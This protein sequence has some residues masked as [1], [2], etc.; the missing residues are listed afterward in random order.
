M[1]IQ[2][3]GEEEEIQGSAQDRGLTFEFW[4]GTKTQK[5]KAKRDTMIRTLLQVLAWVFLISY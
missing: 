2:L 4:T 1:I 5:E 3:E